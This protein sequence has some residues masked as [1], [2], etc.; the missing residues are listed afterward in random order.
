MKNNFKVD[1]LKVN[2]YKSRKEMGEVAGKDIAMKIKKV[3]ET[4]EACNVIF[5]AAPSQNEVLEAVKNSKDVDFTRVNAFHMDEYIGLE[6]DAPQGFAN[7]LRRAIF[8]KVPFKNVFCLRGNVSDIEK[9]CN[10]YSEL[11]QQYPTDIVI[12][13]IGENGHIAFNDPHVANFKDEELVKVVEL[14]HKCRNQQV[15]DGCFTSIDLV[16]KFAL[17][18]TIPA[19]VKSKYIYCIVPAKTKAEAVK[20]TL[21]GEVSEKCPASILRIQK[22][23]TLYLEPD[24]SSLL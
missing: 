3:L 18:L 5:A 20:N 21:Q 12:M 9:E 7:F 11:L 16:P 19:L 2:I 22:N 23:A 13:G 6:D 15:N 4:K 14:D 17:T 8:D 24:S 1:N 10:R